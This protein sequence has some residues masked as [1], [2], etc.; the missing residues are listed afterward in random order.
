[1]AANEIT[2]SPVR[3]LW[4]YNMG[5]FYPYGNTTAV[6]VLEYFLG[7]PEIVINVGLIKL[8]TFSIF[9]SFETLLLYFV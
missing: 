9:F 2:F 1:M 5:S 6:N 4:G 3:N 8:S 7:T